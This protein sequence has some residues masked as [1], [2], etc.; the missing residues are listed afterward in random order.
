MKLGVLL[1]HIQICSMESEQR[2]VEVFGRT[3]KKFRYE[4]YEGKQRL[5]FTL[6]CTYGQASLVSGA[7]ATLNGTETTLGLRI[8]AFGDLAGQLRRELRCGVHASVR[9]M[10][11][12]RGCSKEWG[13]T[14][15]GI[16]AEAMAWLDP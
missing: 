7:Q 16:V 15:N 8:I 4:E 10:L 3:G 12:G 9:G 6:L 5:E 1:Q 14:K 13:K 2:Q 11:I